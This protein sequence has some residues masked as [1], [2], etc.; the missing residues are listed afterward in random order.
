MNKIKRTLKWIIQ[1]K[2]LAFINL[3]LILFMIAGNSYLQIFCQ[4]SLLVW[5]ILIP[6]L[7]F[8]TLIPLCKGSHFFLGCLLGFTFLFWTYCI[9]FLDHFLLYA[10]IS[11]PLL[12]GILGLAPFL[13][14]FQIL[15]KI[16]K[17]RSVK[18]FSGFAFAMLV[19]GVACYYC[20]DKY[21]YNSS[22]LA[23]HDVQSMEHIQANFWTER[24]IGMHIKYHTKVCEF[25]GWRPPLHD[26]FLIIGLRLN[27]Y[28]DA[29]NQFTIEERIAIY[30]NWFP[31]KDLHQSSA[32]A[33]IESGAYHSFFTNK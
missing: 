25:D 22:F 30:N 27:N 16:Y 11:V 2:R 10:V 6:I 29:L 26:P 19:A 31:E 5:S 8:T 28:N 9:L 14:N 12:I 33:C 23:N 13:F 24:I 4:P 17:R 3:F 21:Q 15:Y 1:S 18:V 20:Y 7:S 32:C